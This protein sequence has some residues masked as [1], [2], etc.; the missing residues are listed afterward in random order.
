VRKKGKRKKE[1]GE[2]KKALGGTREHWDHNEVVIKGEKE[3][4]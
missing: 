1:E 3:S 4:S 2:N